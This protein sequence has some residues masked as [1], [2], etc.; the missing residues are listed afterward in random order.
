MARPKK[1]S[2][3]LPT[4]EH[5]LAGMKTINPKLDLGAGCSTTSIEAKIKTVRQK[6]EA[7]NSLLSK[8]DAA[9]NEL[10]RAEKELTGL[11][12]KVLLGVAMKYNKESD[13]YEMVGGVRP[14]ERKRGKRS[15]AK[16]VAV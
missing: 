14:S 15:S 13:Q 6:L 10:E 9:A 7:Y 1:R 5:R 16:L 3:V 2:L 11:S 12:S 8:T 4:A